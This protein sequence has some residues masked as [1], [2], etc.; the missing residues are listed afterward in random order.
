[1]ITGL[2]GSLALIAGTGKLPEMGASFASRSGYP[3]TVIDLTGNGHRFAPFTDQLYE[4]SPFQWGRIVE[5]L[6]QHSVQNI[7][8]LGEVKKELLFTGGQRPDARLARLLASLPNYS[9]MEIFRGLLRDLEREGFIVGPQ[10]DL[11][12]T[13]ACG[14]GQWARRP[15]VREEQDIQIGLRVARSLTELDVGQTV[16]VKDAAVVAVEA[17]EHTDATIRRAAELTG[18]GGIMVKLKRPKQD[19]RFDIPCI[20]PETFALM[21]AARLT[22]LAFS[23]GI[24]WLDQEESLAIARKADISIICISEEGGTVANL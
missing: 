5:I 2:Q 11:V 14:P 20:G 17:M 12:G 10:T 13:L 1:V 7:Y 3:L 6:H 15:T 4:L 23:A 8:F 16:I 18:G 21:S 9:D 24:L 22:A 19:P